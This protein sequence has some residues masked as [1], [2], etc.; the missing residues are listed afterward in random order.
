MNTLELNR[1]SDTERLEI[2]TLLLKA[3]YTVRITYKK[4]DTP[5]RDAIIEYF[6]KEEEK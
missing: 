3:G 6:R 4:N 2:A 5:F 1:L